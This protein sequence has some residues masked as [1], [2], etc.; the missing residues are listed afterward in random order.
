M[1]ALL[2]VLLLLATPAL[3]AVERPEFDPVPGAR[4][5]LA[6]PL[7]DE[8]GHAA[9]L[10]QFMAG[11]PALV[12]F[13]YHDCPNQCGVAQQVVAETLGKTG[14]ADGV[15]PLFITLA[16]EEGPPDA[17]GAKARLLAAAG[18]VAQPWRFLSGSSVVSLSA[19]FGIGAVER[20]R[21][22]Q[23][24]HPIAVYT[25][26][27][28]G[29]ISH[30][31]P[32]LGLSSDD[33]RL[34]LVEASQG[35]LGTVIDQVTLWCAG[36]D[37]TTGRYTAPVIGWLRLAAGATVVIGLAGLAFLELKKRRWTA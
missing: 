5:D 19:Q 1:R 25:V 11:R 6:T 16:P 21:I 29:R 2:L 20:Q 13:G 36:Y 22:Q 23:F 31:L 30:V 26:T 15:T 3:A 34:A 14:L 18:P 33:L 10:G 27:A 8:T 32:G 9:T 7:T 12:L 4:I 37:T 35:R 17:A 28:D 24:V